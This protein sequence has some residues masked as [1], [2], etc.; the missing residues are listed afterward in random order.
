MRPQ[1][2]ELLSP[3]AM[4][5]TSVALQAI[6]LSDQAPQLVTGPW[7]LLEKLGEG[8]FGKVFKARNE[9]TAQLAAVKV[10]PVEQDTGEVQ[11]EIDILMK[12][13]SANIVQYYGSLTKDGELWIIMEFCAGSS[14]SDIM[15][16][17]SLALLPH[18]FVPRDARRH[19]LPTPLPPSASPSLLRLLRMPP[20]GAWSLSERGPDRGRHGGHPCR[21]VLSALPHAALDPPRREGGQSPTRRERRHQTV[22]A[23]SLSRTHAW[24]VPRRVGR[25]VTRARTPQRCDPLARPW[26]LP[27]T[28][29][30]VLPV[31][32][33]QTPDIATRIRHVHCP[34]FHRDHTPQFCAPLDVPSR[35]FFRWALMR[36]PR[37]RSVAAVPISVSPRRSARRCRSAAP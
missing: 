12:C 3:G 7:M 8:S 24:R 21:L 36:A 35:C 23:L 31:A 20:S 17:R 37:L 25:Q 27:A 18:G 29:L 13:S 6:D 32:G 4:A 33:D 1:H 34:A 10:V 28:T 15:E 30:G 14:L 5:G 22:R 26:A 11:R 2:G 9:E 16:V 19:S